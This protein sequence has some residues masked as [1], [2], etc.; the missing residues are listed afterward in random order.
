MTER[1]RWIGLIVWVAVCLGAGG[2]GA[3]ATTPEIAG[4]YKSIAKPSWNPPDSVFGPVWSMLF[5]LMA[6]AGWLVWKPTP[7][8]IS[9]NMFR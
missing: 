8:E 4:W 7:R 3:M 2:L 6:I 1:T 9:V 5:I